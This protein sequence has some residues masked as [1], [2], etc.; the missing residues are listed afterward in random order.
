MPRYPIISNVVQSEDLLSEDSDA[1]W[2]ARIDRMVREKE[3]EEAR[4]RSLHP[5]ERL[6]EDGAKLRKEIESHDDM[7]VVLEVSASSR[8]TCRA[9][10][11]CFHIRPGDDHERAAIHGDFRIRVNGVRGEFS[12][13]RTTHFYHILC[14]I[15]MMDVEELIPSKKF[16]FERGPGWGLMVMKWEMH[17]GRVNLDVLAKFIDDMEQWEKNKENSTSSA[18]SSPGIA[19]GDGETSPTRPPAA[20]QEAKPVL[21]IYVTSAERGANLWELMEHPYIWK[22]KPF[23]FPTANGPKAYG[24]W[25]EVWEEDPPPEEAGTSNQGGDA[26][27]TTSRPAERLV[28]SIGLS[29]YELWDLARSDRGRRAA[30]LAR[31]QDAHSPRE[32]DDVSSDTG[33]SEEVVQEAESI[34]KRQGDHGS[35]GDER[36]AKRRKTTDEDGAE[37]EVELETEGRVAASEQQRN[38]NS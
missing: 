18:A 28:N 12:H 29:L 33:S 14:F 3:A 19:D 24:P 1:E 32:T 2:R 22:A 36:S 4:R 21:Q 20:T 8:S 27:D 10:R 11:D 25:A 37:P 17:R 7:S 34:N 13:W 16:T 38:E 30:G 35:S 26:A 23:V 31:S 6:A 5:T 15:A 9:G